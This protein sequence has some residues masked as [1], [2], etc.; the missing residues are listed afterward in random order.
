M[1]G[2]DRVCE[3][4]ILGFGSVPRP[5]EVPVGICCSTVCA[6]LVVDSLDM[7]IVYFTKRNC[8]LPVSTRSS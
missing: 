4:K 2:F 5:A 6:L 7:Y 8:A 3:S 1:G